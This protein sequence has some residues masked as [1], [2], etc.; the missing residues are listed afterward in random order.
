MKTRFLFGIAACAVAAP[1][2][3]QDVAPPDDDPAAKE[4]I[5]AAVQT[6]DEEAD[7]LDSEGDEEAIVITGTR[8]PGAVLGD[9]EPEVQLDRREIRALGAGSVG[10]LLEYLSPQTRSGRGRGGERPVVL[11]NGRRISG[12]REIRDLPPEAIIRV[13]VLPEEAALQYGYR[14][15]QRVVNFVLRPRFRA[16]TT[17][18]DGGLATAGGRASYGAKVNVLGLNR[19]GRSS[20]D[21]QFRHA[22]PLFESDRDILQVDPIATDLGEFRSLLTE[23]D[24]F[25]LGG[26]L[27][28][29]V[30]GDVSATFN[31]T[32]DASS[33]RSFLG[34]REGSVDDGLVRESD[35][36]AG[37]LGFVLNGDVAPWR[38]SAIGNYDLSE[39]ETRTD[40]NGMGDRAD[41]VSEVASM[42]GTASG[43]IVD[44]P[45][46]RAAASLRAGFDTRSLDSE[47]LRGGLPQ[48]RELSRQR[49][50]VQASLDIP[51]ASRRRA[52]LEA[53]GDLS[54]NFNAELEQL[55]DFGT[56]RT[57]GAGLN[58]EP[59]PQLDF[60][61][62]YTD[63]DGAPSMQQLGDPV[64]L[65]PSVRVFDFLQGETVEIAR[66]EGGNP[67]LTADNRRVLKLGLTAKPLDETDLSI[68]ANYTRNRI[69]NVIASF[70]T[71]T[72]EI[73]A[74]FPERFTRDSGGRLTQIDSRPVNFERS[75]RDEFR[76]G[77][78]FSKRL[79]P[80]PPQ[81]PEGGWR[82]RGRDNMGA[83]PGGPGASAESGSE[84]RPREAGQG[85]SGGGRGGFGGR[86]GGGF[87]GGR[88]GRLQLGLYHNWVL[89]D[90]ILIRDGLAPLDLLNGSAVGS[91]GGRPEHEIEFQA[92][93][94]KNGF[95]ARLSGTWHSGTFVRGGP[96]GSGGE[97]SDLF[98]S[99]QATLNLRLFADL[100]A[101]RSLVRDHRW[102]RGTRVSL[103][104]DNLFDSR[105]QVRDSSGA[106][107]LSYQPAYLDPL[108]R[109]VRLTLRKLF[110]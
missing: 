16:V 11:L 30:F 87:G 97:R 38:W 17:E 6:E 99:D 102:L 1:G 32:F 45:G 13:D 15:D 80:P 71:A 64:L 79:G 84:Q 19:S 105:P 4:A 62:S 41:T 96:D 12:F 54:L 56:L 37:H 98:F 25:S 70:P 88:V 67:N 91:R 82:R 39:I 5:A 29:N 86:R 26:T 49:G 36:L 72:P 65:T 66:L 73:E 34:L 18:V 100:G 60:N 21:V 63:E 95:G 43:P 77:V 31:T 24:Q 51:I 33:N 101:Q 69:D 92:N 7:Y 20:L 85:R 46:G 57:L 2:L 27:N 76:W 106:T 58:W 47:T 28:R 104:I 59:I 94:S 74:A 22:D 8:E 53:I 109:S 10:E 83:P 3:A 42:E 107:P 55:S 9:I 14:P 108:G 40:R 93:V 48:S 75:A 90:E 89:H 78:N 50:H 61:F 103:S 52:V 23:T 44:L 81:R 110:F 35:T 68:V